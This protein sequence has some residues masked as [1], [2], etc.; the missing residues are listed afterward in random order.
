MYHK[1]IVLL[2]L[3]CL[4]SQCS[5]LGFILCSNHHY[6]I[7]EKTKYLTSLEFGHG[8]VTEC[9]DY[10]QIDNLLAFWIKLPF[11]CVTEVSKDR[12]GSIMKFCPK[13]YRDRLLPSII[14]DGLPRLRF[15]I[16]PG[17][18]WCRDGNISRYDTELGI[19]KGLESC[20]R[21]HDYCP[22]YIKA[23]QT[24]Y[25]ITNDKMGTI[26]SCDCDDKL[27]ECLH[28]VNHIEADNI[29]FI[30]ANLLAMP[31]FKKD[32][33]I[34]KCLQNGG[35]LAM[36]QNFVQ[37]LLVASLYGQCSG[38]GY[39][40]CSDYHYF[41]EEKTNH[42]TYLQFGLS[43][44]TECK[45]YGNVNTLQAFFI[46]LPFHC[47]TKVSNQGLESI[48]KFCPKI[49]NDQLLSSIIFDQLPKFAPK[50]NPGIKV[51]K[52][53]NNKT[54]TNAISGTYWCGAGNISR[55]N[56]DIDLGTLSELDSCCRTHDHCPDF[57]D[58]D[59]TKYGI[60]NDKAGTISSCNCDDT[61]F[62]CLHDVKHVTADNVGFIF[63]NVLAMPCFK[64]EYPIV[65]CVEYEGFL[66]EQCKVYQLDTSKKPKY[67]LFDSKMAQSLVILFLLA[68]CGHCSG[69][70]FLLCGNSHYYIEEET[71]HLTSA[72][73][74]LGGVTEC[75]DYGIISKLQAFWIKLPFHCVTEVTNE[76]LESVMKFCPKIY[77]DRLLLNLILDSI[78]KFSF[79]INP[80]TNWCGAGNISKSDID[81]GTL[82]KLD[83]CCRTHDHCPDYI[84][85][86]ETK[87]GITNN[88]AGT[89][90]N[91]HCDDTFF[92]CLHDVQH[93]SADNVGFLFA[94]VL[95]MPCF[96]E[97]Y[98]IVKCIEYGGNFFQAFYIK[99]PHHCVTT[100]NEEGLDSVMKLCPQ[101]QSD[102]LISSLILDR[103]PKYR[104]NIFPGTKWCG[105]GNIASSP[106]DVGF[107]K[108][109]DSCCKVHD[110][111][112]EGIPVGETIHGIKNTFS[113]TISHC[114]CDETFYNCLRD[115]KHIAANNVGF[116]F[117]NILAMP[118]F[119]KDY[120]IIKCLE[121]GGLSNSQC[122]K[123]E[124]DLS[125]T[126]KTWQLFDSK[127]YRSTGLK[128]VISDILL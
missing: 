11:H 77:K 61:F 87:Y 125:K 82:A 18:Y 69:L 124:H 60:T 75:K 28:E 76:G 57:I 119:K 2:L 30:F 122:Q 23:G 17:T 110:Q 40:F 86:D 91:C 56:K 107:F 55:S 98:P 39:I 83:S 103:L 111:C 100:V 108:K 46:K 71:N 52:L 41:I 85:V 84:N 51:S 79:K 47:V 128:G 36:Y 1:L 95:G 14:L 96:K 89:I 45:D 121:K 90:S 7:E 9:R 13:I 16:D 27:Y 118:C 43:G 3:S 10:G 15:N 38:L 117:F 33:P 101:I 106:D 78:P 72:K 113:G 97:E 32:Y 31:C 22:D 4:C 34:V 102:R 20:C 24:K 21:I 53:V 93:I 8:G 120:P 94:N 66:N 50:I 48:M 44:I 67:Q 19:F 35:Y 49:Y 54:V 127:L 92:Q 42:L 99:L 5:A 114:D 80:G 112:P 123:Y 12:L 116:T 81:L 63:F 25:G 109:L 64:K 58:V 73:F 126:E 29:G 59:Q 68:L 70:G 37:Y 26:S 115:V 62:Q 6:F 105:A 74:G 65:K 88:Q 104:Y